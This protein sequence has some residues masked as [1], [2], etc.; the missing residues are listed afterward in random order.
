ME[1]G[2]FPIG[3]THTRTMLVSED[4]S[5]GANVGGE[6]DVA[7]VVARLVAALEP[8]DV[9]LGG[10]NVKQLDEL[11]RGCRVGDNANAFIGGF[12]LWE[13]ASNGKRAA[14]RQR[15]PNTIH[16]ETKGRHK[17]EQ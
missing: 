6:G 1:L 4:W 17:W 5:S 15:V 12:R 16:N 7:E 10:G 9:A 2:T 3:S 14:T 11:P 13:H 8:D